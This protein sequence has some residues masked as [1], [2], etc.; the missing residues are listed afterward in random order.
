M[1]ITGFVSCSLGLAVPS[2]LDS[3]TLAWVAAVVANGGTV[4]NGRKTLVNNLIV[5]LK[6]DGVWTKLDR[7]VLLAAENMQSALTDLVTGFFC[8]VNG[9]PAF[10][11]DRGYTG[12]DG[13][14][15]DYIDILFV[16]S[17]NGV[18]YTQNAAS[19][20]IWNVTN[21]SPASGGVGM[22]TFDATE[23]DIYATYLDGNVYGRIND[24]PS[25]GSQGPPATRAGHWFLNRSGASTSQIYQNGS[26]FGSPNG[27]SG[28]LSNNPMY[29]LALGG[30][31][32][33]ASTGSPQ[34]QAMA[35]IGGN[36]SSTNV[37]NFYN[38]LRTYMTAVGVP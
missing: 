26:L 13:S 15:T 5:G 8:T 4:S 22:G 27:T 21:I 2:T 30:V 1:P 20:S 25:S 7:L 38:R 11:V 14:T 34:Q 18:N 23:T 6:F 12:V 28:A 9:S 37:A 17:L 24:T 19:L 3:A 33:S 35:S 16:P 32:N 36:L 10:T 31:A 29:I